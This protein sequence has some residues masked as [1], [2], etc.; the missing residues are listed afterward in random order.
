MRSATIAAVTTR[1]MAWTFG[2]QQKL[3]VGFVKV[4][5]R[6]AIANRAPAKTGQTVAVVANERKARLWSDRFATVTQ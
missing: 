3:P 2:W 4:L 1:F 6:Y 5:A